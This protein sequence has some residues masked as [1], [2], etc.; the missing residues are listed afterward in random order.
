MTSEKLNYSLEDLGQTIASY[1]QSSGLTQAEVAEKLGL[2]N[3]AVSRLERGQTDPSLRR[4]FEIAELFNCEV[5]DLLTNASLRLQ[6]QTRQV[7]NL[8]SLL[9]S[10]AERTEVIGI[11]K[12]IIKFRL[13][14]GD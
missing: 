5:A 4:L 11:L 13:R 2:G 12:E 14:R 7:A 6:D 8:L 3:D 9:D 1:R 10:E